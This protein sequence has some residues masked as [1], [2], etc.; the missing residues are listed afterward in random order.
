MLDVP[1]KFCSILFESDADSFGKE[2]SEMPPFFRDLNLD[3]IVDAVTAC[4]E[5]YN[6]KPLFHTR[7][8]NTAQIAYRQEIMRDLDNP[9]VLTQLTTFATLMDAVRQIL[10]ASQKSDCQYHKE[11]YFLSASERYCQAIEQL[12]GGLQSSRIHSLG[13]RLFRAYLA[14]YAASERFRTLAGEAETTRSNLSA[15]RYCLV[16]GE[17]KI[18]VRDYDSETDYTSAV[19]ETFARFKQGA[20]KDYTIKFPTSSGMNHI[21]VQVLQRVALL[22]PA[23]FD[24]L[25]KFC[26]AHTDFLDKSIS[27]FDREIQ[28]YI[29][30]IEYQNKFKRIGLTFCYPTVSSTSKSVNSRNSFDL[31]L[32]GKLLAR[33]T[34]VVCNDFVLDGAERILV[35]SGPNQGG[36]TTLSRT[37]G[38]LHYLAS[39]GCSV[40]G[41]TANLFFF[42]RLLTHFEREEDISTLRGKLQDDLARIHRILLEATSKSIIIMNEIFSST[43]VDDGL[44]LGKKVLEKIS[45]LDVLCV[46]VTFLDELS[47][48]NDKTVS[49]VATIAPE[50]PVSR[51]YRIERKPA[52]GLAYALA[53]AEKHQ[54]TYQWLSRRLNP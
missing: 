24:A 46:C 51:T 20:V 8:S 4:K 52:D 42:D 37:F 13:M 48:L 34:P 27:D 25:D 19:E 40:P 47:R 16:L 7:L 32:A 1:A 54:V 45:D 28:F 39:L 3:Q 17:G 30:W 33:K 2:S 15:I 10:A 11:G 22:N 38:Q 41:D 5:Q 14:D 9:T 12:L 23:A 21:D 6:L 50:N 26:V 29:A 44:Y 49:M 31:A 53:I 35:I 43:S 18:V 36:K